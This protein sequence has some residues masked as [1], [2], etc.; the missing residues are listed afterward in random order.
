[1]NTNTPHETPVAQTEERKS[2]RRAVLAFTLAALAVGGIG[3]AA[4]S[5]AWTDNVFYSAKAEAATF[6]LQ[7]S[8]NGTS[9]SESD[10]QGSIQLA[11]PASALANLVP[12]ESRTINLY[13][14][15]LGSVGAALTSSVAWAS[16][17]A[18][19]FA[20]N[21]GTSVEGL[22]TALTAVGGAT[23]TDQ[24]QLKVTTD[25]NWAAAN[26]GKSGTI[27]VTVSGTAVAP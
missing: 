23:D 8:L 20:T 5:A 6:N 2:K 11:V 19:T 18:S 4:T 22:A 14:K 24:F 9:W 21:P 12:G 10:A 1:M 16:S 13:V 27:I 17:P 15:N 26:Q 3:A 7:G 25:A